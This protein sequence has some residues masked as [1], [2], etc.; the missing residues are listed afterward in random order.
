MKYGH[1]LMHINRQHKRRRTHTLTL[2]H[3]FAY[4]PLYACIASHARLSVC[5]CELLVVILHIRCVCIDVRVR[6]CFRCVSLACD[7][8]A[9]GVAHDMRC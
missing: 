9:S 6:V 4:Q 3:M 7:V 2:I 5:V 1:E 8:L